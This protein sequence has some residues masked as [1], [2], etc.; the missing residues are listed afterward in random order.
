M[1][2]SFLLVVLIFISLGLFQTL[3]AAELVEVEVV[4]KDYIMVCFKDGDVVFDE[5]GG[6]TDGTGGSHA[7][8]YGEALNTG[9]ATTAGNWTI[10]SSEDSNYGASGASPDAVYRQSR[11]NGM[12]KDGWGSGDWNWEYT[13]EHFIYLKLPSSMQQENEYTIDIP[14]NINCDT[15]AQSLTYDIFNCNSEAVHINLIGYISESGKKTADLYKFFGDGGYRDYSGFEG[16]DVYIY[17]VEAETSQKVGSVSFWMQNEAE[18]N[19]NMTGG[20]VWAIDFTGF[21]QPGT[22]RLA[23]EGIGCSQD[24]EIKDKIYYNPFKVSVQGYFYMR[25]GQETYPSGKPEPRTPLYIP[26]ESPSD[27]KVYVTDMH[28][29]H[30]D[31]GSFSSG[32]VWDAPEDW[33]AYKKSGEPTNPDAVGGHSDAAD[34][35]RHL[36]HVVNIYDLCLAYIMSDGRISDDDLN[37]AESGNGIPDILDEARNEVDFWL[38]LRYNG[39]YS[40]GLTNPDDNNDLYQAGNTGVAAWANA[41]NSSMLAYCFQIAGLT[42]LKNTY[43]DSAVNAY[44]YADN[45]SEPM[46]DESEEGIRGRDFKMM[47]AA[48][49]YNLTGDTEYEDVVNDLSVVESS[50]SDVYSDGTYN[51]VWGT[52]AYLMTNRSV[53]YPDLQT[54]MKEVI[55]NRAKSREADNVYSRPSRRG[56]ADDKYGLN[57]WQTYQGM[58]RTVIAH[59]VSDDQA[60]KDSLLNALFMEADWGLGRNPLN[61][62]QMTTATTPLSD[63]RSVENCYTSG[64]DDGTAGVHPGHTPYLNT[65]A[66][67]SGGMIGNDPTPVLDEFYPDVSNWPHASKYINT[68]Y[69]WSHS[70]FTPRQT[71]RGKTLLYGYLY[72]IDKDSLQNAV[73]EF[74]VT[75]KKG[76]EI[77]MSPNPAMDKLNVSLSESKDITKIL[78][79]TI[80]GR[81]VAERGVE[82]GRSIVT[83]NMEHLPSVCLILQLVTK[84]GKKINRKINLAR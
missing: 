19:W 7:V 80:D 60:E 2:R 8:Y 71:M 83:V 62:I 37:I 57:W 65:E 43:R 55:I 64:L 73:D 9:N 44:S 41:L 24:F 27:C 23:V 48:Y 5:D 67:S 18:T 59:A 34:W 50:S 46:L 72:G 21:N 74:S 17:D 22:Y 52:A 25:I 70:E 66:W 76:V 11:I 45:S 47:A 15:S 38:D 32:D 29:Y 58:Q 75:K 30:S 82:S 39:G 20:D 28:P 40:H 84:N 4:D 68:R 36:G 3:Q 42:D 31:W 51:Q 14:G 56:Y 61:M 16:N 81:V 63:K 54:N 77:S 10:T 12:D 1:I 53:N 33:V 6:A 78:L 35:D 26:N 69:I 79:Y 49:L 13:K